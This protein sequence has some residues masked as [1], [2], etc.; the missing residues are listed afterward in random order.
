MLKC[1]WKIKKSFVWINYVSF[2]CTF[3]P[4]THVC[5]YIYILTVENA[6]K[7]RI[8]KSTSA[9]AAFYIEIDALISLNT[10]S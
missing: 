9:V 3:G 6:G 1:Y 7:E 8:Y 5:V 2:D 10:L 4:R